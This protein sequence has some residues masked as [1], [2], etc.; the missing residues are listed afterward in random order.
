VKHLEDPKLR[1]AATHATDRLVVLL[2]PA[3]KE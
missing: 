2:A 3:K 1:G